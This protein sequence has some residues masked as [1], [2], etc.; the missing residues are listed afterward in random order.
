MRITDVTIRNA[1]NGFILEWY[2][3]Q[4]NTM[5]YSDMEELFTAIK[6]LLLED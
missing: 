5:I 1:N 3:D 2:D 4:S 6:E